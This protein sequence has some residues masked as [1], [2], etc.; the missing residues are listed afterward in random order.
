MG[1][2]TRKLKRRHRLIAGLLAVSLLAT[3]CGGTTSNDSGG[4]NG[5]Q[6]NGDGSLEERGL[7]AESGESGL[8]EAGDPVR[9]GKLVYGMEADSNT[10]CLSEGQLAISG[11]L[12]VRAI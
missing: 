3:A 5:G 6:A 2:A 12:V 1:F 7:T 11:M 4:G 9:G 10:F 8:D